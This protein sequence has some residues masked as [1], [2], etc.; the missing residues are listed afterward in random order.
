MSNA[1]GAA[2]L[3][4]AATELGIARGVGALTLQGVASAGGVSK[5]LVLYHFGGKRTLLETLARQLAAARTAALQG[6]AS[7]PDPMSGWRALARDPRSRSERALLASLLQEEELRHLAPTLAASQEAAA[8]ALAARVLAALGLRPR[9]SAVL[10]GRV[11]L[12][13]LDGLALGPSRDAPALDAEL[14]AMALAL[15]ALGD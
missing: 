7:A 10:L 2:R 3:L 14:D 5:A 9:V 12:H 4:E 15:L 13:H 8:T 11:L 1:E 6:T